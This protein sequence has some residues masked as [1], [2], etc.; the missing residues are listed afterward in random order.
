MTG[1]F[2]TKTTLRNRHRATATVLVF[3]LLVVLPLPTLHA[4]DAIR[5]RIY[6]GIDLFPAF[7]AANIDIDKQKGP[8]NK[9]LLVLLYVTKEED[10]LMMAK[11]LEKSQQIRGI[12]IRVE[13][14]S[15]PTLVAFAGQPVAGI[16][17]CQ[18]RRHDLQKVLK[19]A[20]NRHALVFS[21][22][23]GDVEAGIHGG[24]AVRD[25][26]LPFINTTAIHNAGIHLKQFFLRI[27]KHH[28]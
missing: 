4:A 19:A 18:R 2:P 5:T 27:A 7:L 16:F 8:D 10:C 6:A 11:R 15:D 23:A 9:L 28:E 13:L 26:I 1:N 3:L 25:R 14:S 20:T 24:I 12:P 17:L 21:P 22:F